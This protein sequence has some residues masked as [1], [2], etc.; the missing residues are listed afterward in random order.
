VAVTVGVVGV[1]LLVFYAPLLGDIV[2]S[3]GQEFGRKLPWHGPL[4]TPANDLLGPNVQFVSTSD[5]P[6]ELPD[7]SVAGDNAIAGAI[8]VMGALLLWRTGARMLTALLVVPPLFV[9]LVLT[10]GRFFVEPR[11]AAF[12]L[13]HMIVLAACGVVG[14]VKLIPVGLARGAA[15]A[16]AVLAASLATVHAVQAGRAIHE[17]PL[18]NFKEAAKVAR[19]QPGSVVFTDSTR[20]Q[21]L[22][23]YLGKDSVLQQPP[24]ELERLFCYSSDPIVYVEH[25]FR[26]SPNEAPPPDLRCLRRRGA[27]MVRLYQRGR[28]EHIDVWILAP[29]SG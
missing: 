7:S 23:Y 9:Y 26:G 22:Q 24:A 12:L 3:T 15:A 28:G 10:L 29:D 1:I 8:A 4:S 11:F 27:R 14:L 2:D 13:F 16:G 18:E 17:L 19:A 5:L 6:T 20:P 25:P 21:G